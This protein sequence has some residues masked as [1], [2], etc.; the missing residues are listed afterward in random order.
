M[1]WKSIQIITINFSPEKIIHRFGRPSLCSSEV[2]ILGSASRFSRK[3]RRAALELLILRRSWKTNT[4]LETRKVGRNGFKQEKVVSFELK[5]MTRFS[6]SGSGLLKQIL[7]G[8]HILK[9]DGLAKPGFLPS[10]SPSSRRPGPPLP[11]LPRLRR[12]LG[13]SR[14]RMMAW[15]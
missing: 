3:L 14:V 10:L 7:Y 8:H 5:L 11:A 6:E 2:L 9:Q 4:G 1:L 13:G 15:K 12:L